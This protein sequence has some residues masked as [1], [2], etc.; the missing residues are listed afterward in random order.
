[1]KVLFV[2]REISYEPLGL[3]QVIS[4][5]KGKGHEIDLV[6]SDY[7]DPVEYAARF[8]PDLVGYNCLTG[9]YRYYSEINRRIKE[10]METFSI[11]GGPHPT[12]FP[13]LINESGVDAICIGEGDLAVPQ[14]IE[15]YKNGGDYHHTNNWWVKRG[16]EIVKNPLGPLIMDLDSVPYVDRE[17]LYSKSTL[18]RKSKLKTFLFSRGCPFDC[19]YCFNHQFHLLYPSVGKKIRARSADSIIKE[20]KNVRDAYPLEFISI[21]DDVFCFNIE[22]LREFSCKY[23][24]EIGLP[25]YCAQRADIVNEERTRLLKEANCHAISIGIESG[26]QDY[27]FKYLKKHVTDEQIKNASKII[28]ES[29]I[30]LM[31]F[32]ILGL[33]AGGVDDDWQTL[34]FNIECKPDFSAVFFFQPYPKTEL[35]EFAKKNNFLDGSMEEIG[36]S[37]ADR[38]IIKF[39]TKYEKRQIERLLRLFPITVRWPRLLSLTRMLIKLPMDG[40]YR[41]V[42]KVYKGYA[43]RN[44]INPYKM[45]IIEYAQTLKRYWKRSGG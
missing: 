19:S 45:T 21:F 10:R 44:Y 9:S 22:L 3:M 2:A 43:L 40:L 37:A 36:N 24:K 1:M 34:K 4:L 12:F 26:K 15:R 42:Y 17:I 38:S 16:D 35:G 5:L 18:A 14:F 8:K 11:F 6:I 32:N 28:K 39:K 30:R 20:I 41:F 27:R 13:E 7:E 23:K 25:F 31:T 29:G 33:P